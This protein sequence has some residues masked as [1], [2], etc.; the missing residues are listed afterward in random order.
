MDYKKL[1]FGPLIKKIRLAKG[2]YLKE[3]ASKTISIAQL[4]RFE[5]GKSD[6]SSEKF[7]H[8]LDALLIESNEFES[9]YSN[10]T[11]QSLWKIFDISNANSS[12]NISEIEENLSY[13]SKMC[14]TGNQTTF[15][16]LQESI[17]RGHLSI[18]KSKPELVT[19]HDLHRIHSYLDKTHYFGTFECKL[20]IYLMN[21]DGLINTHRYILKMLDNNNIFKNNHRTHNA[22]LNVLFNALA[23]S[24]EENYLPLANQYLS[25]VKSL[26]IY[27]D[28]IFHKAE[29]RFA[30][31]CIEYLE[32]KKK[33][34]ISQMYAIIEAL[35]LLGETVLANNFKRTLNIIEK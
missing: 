10:E 25:A 13:A 6:I 26:G 14:K 3:I 1:Q 16:K 31:A 12:L 5:S 2:F 11:G 35:E 20:M 24:I 9:F 29:F 19:S 22:I 18:A 33:E 27:H 7:Y 17:L 30:E 4:S 28:M 23:T 8:I 32:S 21:Y 15:W 34:S